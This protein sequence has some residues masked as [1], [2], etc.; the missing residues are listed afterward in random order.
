VEILPKDP[1]GQVNIDAVSVE[2]YRREQDAAV[3][4]YQ[5]SQAEDDE[6]PGH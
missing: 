2:A 1:N 6:Q 4:A 5:D 3:Q